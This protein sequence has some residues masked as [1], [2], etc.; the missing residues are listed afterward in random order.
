MTHSQ[1]CSNCISHILPDRRTETNLKTLKCF[2]RF[3][4]DVTL[5]S[6]FI[7]VFALPLRFLMLIPCSLQHYIGF[8]VKMDLLMMLQS[9]SALKLQIS[10]FFSFFL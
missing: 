6:S 2:L 1:V 4:V 3:I 5:F 9:L 10:F 7:S 8:I